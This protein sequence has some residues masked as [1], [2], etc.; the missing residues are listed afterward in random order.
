MNAPKHRKFRLNVRAAMILGIGTLTAV[1]GFAVLSYVRSQWEQPALLKQALQQAERTPPNYDLALVYLN[2][3][4]VSHPKDPVALESKAKI[5]ADIAS[6]GEQLREAIKLAETAIRLE[7][8]APRAQAL[9]KLVVET[10]L[11]MG[12]FQPLENLRMHTAETTVREMI[13][14]GDKSPE[15]L[16]LLAQVLEIQAFLGD[17][18]ALDEAATVYEQARKL[19]P[20]NIEGAE[21]LA[22]MYQNPQGLN[23]PA[24]A[25]NVMNVMLKANQDA[26]RDAKTPEARHTTTQNLARAYLARYRH[27]SQAAQQTKSLETRRTL[28]ADASE[29]LRQALAKAPEDFNILLT[30]AENELRRGD[31][32]K[33]RSFFDRIPA[34]P[35]NQRDD[36]D[37]MQLRIVQGMIDL[38]ENR[39]DE[40]IESWQNGLIATGG[41]SADLTWRLAQ[42]QLQ[43][44]RLD[45]A[46]PLIQQHRR[47]SGG[48]EP[49][50]AHRYL[51][52]MKLYQENQPRNAIEILGKALPEIGPLLEPRLRYM[53]GQCYEKVQDDSAA[54][55]QYTRAAAAEPR[56]SPPRLARVRLLQR[57]RPLD[58][59]QE[60]TLIETELR[61]DPLTIANGARLALQRELA[62]PL[63]E[64]DWDD[65]SQRIARLKSVSPGAPIAALLEADLLLNTG[66]LPEAAALLEQATRHDKREADLWTAWAAALD[67]LNKPQDALRVLEQA[68]A[69]DAAGDTAAL[70][71]ARARL[72]TRLGN[73]KQAREALVR[74]D[75]NLKPA[76][77]PLVWAELGRMLQQRHEDDQARKAFQKYAE[78]LPDDPAPQ[79]ELMNLALAAGDR[80]AALKAM[81]ALKKITG[82]TG[83]YYRVASAQDLLRE[84]PEG[85]SEDPAARA[86]RYAQ[87]EKLIDE[88]EQSAPQERYAYLMRGLL[89][90]RR[91]ETSEAIAS[92]ERGLVHGGGD[93]AIARLVPLYTAEGRFEDLKALRD[94]QTAKAAA[95]TELGAMEAFRRGKKEVAEQLAEQLVAGNPESLDA[96]VWQARMLNSLGKPEEAE[97]TLRDLV[98]RHPE[99]AGP[100]LALIFFQ[101]GRKQNDAA[102]NTVE[103]MKSKIKFKEGDLPEFLYAQ[104]YRAA[105]DTA[106]AEAAYKKALEA[107]PTNPNV[108]R[109]LFELAVTTNQA[110]EAEKTLRDY[111]AKAPGQRWAVRGLAVFLAEHPKDAGSWQTAWDLIKDA[112]ASG[113]TAE[114]RLARAMVLLRHPEKSAKYGEVET[115]LTQL[116]DDVPADRPAAVTARNLLQNLY[117][118]QGKKDKAH[119]LAAIGAADLSNPR[120]LALYIENL[121]R[122]G[123]LDAAA[124]QLKRLTALAPDDI[125]T[126]KLRAFLL[127]AQKK[128]G[129]AVA[130]LQHAF[131]QHADSAGGEASCREIVV[132]FGALDGPPPIDDPKAGTALAERLAKRWPG[133]SWMLARILQ[134]QGKVSETRVLE[135]CK[136]SVDNGLGLDLLEASKIAIAL[137]EAPN[138]D[139]EVK[140]RV[141]EILAVAA[142]REPNNLDVMLAIAT[143]RY[144]QGRFEDAVTA[145]RAAWDARPSNPAFLNNLAWVLS[146]ELNRPEEGLEVI[147]ELFGRIPA[148]PEFL[149]TRA[150]IHARLGH[151][152]EALDDWKKAAAAQP[153]NPSYCYR[154]ARAYL[155]AGD[156]ANFRAWMNAAKKNHLSP[157]DLQ[158]NERDELK[159]LLLQAS[160]TAEATPPSP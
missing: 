81:D 78:L 143:L 124:A 82:P 107:A 20:L 38:A 2:Q 148:R 26:A 72:L 64:R 50:A 33:A 48:A 59:Q 160:T 114:D 53:L 67:Q 105:G 113:D 23:R 138:A 155:K 134:H 151:G 83:L 85:Q 94:G 55:E 56:W 66:K 79:L 135:L 119:D 30:A 139:D 157:A 158:P 57:T 12:Q 129:E 10:D 58:A 13:A 117:L 49:T 65:V 97:K 93:A 76:D 62:K 123:K 153:E 108:V 89:H 54:L 152:A 112:P 36:R 68:A 40:A 60:V 99:D 73:G 111:L 39:P 24:D 150:S 115:I 74:G 87:A 5:L 101:I 69:P 7:P 21:M 42:I 133:S 1:S 29:E 63:K 130:L 109:A 95:I 116:L 142:K 144:T 84:T 43:L 46:E 104:C 77:R 3:Y 127:N 132:M 61:D 35:E 8:E 110:A 47:L 92:Y 22:R 122:D 149:D 159:A 14:K 128:H 9:R 44:G 32:A 90:E 100:W 86:A 121:I 103:Q 31:V 102:L 106:K 141:D 11:R 136:T 19:D 25:E 156:Q 96:H 4:L 125:L 75:E 17:R 126:L 70:R 88:I 80:D 120:A 71:I 137:A 37:R 146:E 98:S 147:N 18:K 16:R 118:A 51:Q 34:D 91:G 45:E 6:N 145:Y 140:T 52:A 131:D 28:L 27:L 15:A 154:L 41:T